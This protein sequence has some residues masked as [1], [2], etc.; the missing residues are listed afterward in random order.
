[1]TAR[2]PSFALLVLWDDTGI[3]FYRGGRV[4]AKATKAAFQA[5]LPLEATR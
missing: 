3:Q 1:M 5:S 4:D 2:A